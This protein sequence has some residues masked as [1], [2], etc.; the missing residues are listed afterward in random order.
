MSGEMAQWLRD[1]AVLQ[2]DLSS[3][4][5]GSSQPPGTAVPGDPMT[6]EA[7]AHMCTD[8]HTGTHTHNLYK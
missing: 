6:V 1:C 4:E 8:P 2:E 7:H 5:L 3:A